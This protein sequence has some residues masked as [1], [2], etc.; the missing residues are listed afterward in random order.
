MRVVLDSNVL[1]SGLMYPEGTPGR[2]VRAWREGRFDL[3]ISLQQIEEIGRT[4]AYPKIRK[5]LGW[6][7]EAI[8]RFLRQIYLRAEMIE[9]AG[10]GV[11]GLR[12]PDDAPLIETLARSGAEALV[13]GDRDLLVLADRYRV[14]TPSEFARRL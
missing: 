1:L 11:A 13:T 6:D 10:E 4:L 14:E 3:V 5:V 8:G 7:E 2:I 9:L 12:D